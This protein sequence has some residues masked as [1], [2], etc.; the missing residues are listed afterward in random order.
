MKYKC[1]CELCRKA[2]QDEYTASKLK[3]ALEFIRTTVEE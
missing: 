2:R 3:A 1:R